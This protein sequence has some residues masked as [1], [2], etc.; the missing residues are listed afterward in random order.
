MER[1]RGE[2]NGLDLGTSEADS[3]EGADDGEQRQEFFDKHDEPLIVLLSTL[4]LPLELRGQRV[5]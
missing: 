3:Q 4:H 1:P 5:P 2:N